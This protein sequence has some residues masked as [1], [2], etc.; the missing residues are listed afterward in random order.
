MKF[1]ICVLLFFSCLLLSVECSNNNPADLSIEKKLTEFVKDKDAR[2]GISVISQ[3]GDTISI[4]GN[5]SF[6]MLSV[7][8]FPQALAVADFCI[9]NHISFSDTIN[10]D[11][12]QI[13]PDTYSPLREKYGIVDLRLP[14]A[15][16]LAYSLQSS[17]NNACDILFNLIGGP[18]IAANYIFRLGF[19][20]IYIR[21]TEV[22]MHKDLN[23]CYV[24]CSTPL[25]MCG[26]LSH[27]SKCLKHYNFEYNYIAYLMESCQTGL[28]RLPKGLCAGDSLGHKTGTGDTDSND[29][30]IA[31]ND[32]GYFQLSNGKNY[33]IVVFIRDSSYDMETTAH[34]IGEISK[35]VASFYR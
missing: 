23:L 12:S 34:L 32:A 17:D 13:H 25:E 2:I 20:D 6:P 35:M 10:I 7:Y 31:I 8:K 29:K 11:K 27:F 30:I 15:E 5:E 26:L 33:S 4:N 19:P 18:E 22:E 9:K 28:E 1:P 21:S 16:L 14:I 24:N 3:E